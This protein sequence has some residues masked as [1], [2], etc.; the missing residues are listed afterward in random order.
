MKVAALQ[1]DV[2]SAAVEEN[3]ETVEQGLRSA[4][5]Q[6]VRLLVLPEMWASS[7]CEATPE[8]LSASAAAVDR[9]RELSRELELVVAG[10]AWGAPDAAGAPTNRLSI[11]EGGKL[12]LEYDKVHLFSPTAED[13]SFAAGGRPPAV[14][15]SGVGRLSGVLCYDLRF[16]RLFEHLA[17]QGVELLVVPAQWPGAR[18][19]HWRALIP[20]RAVELQAAVVAANRVGKAHVGRRKME[21]EFPGES[22]LVDAH[23]RLQAEAGSGPQLVVAELDPSEPG[24]LRRRVPVEKDR[25]SELYEEW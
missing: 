3:L 10:S 23:G 18:F 9:V 24:R 8:L 5:G 7:F 6:G 11:H 21:L 16:G 4:A 2:L 22:M 1:F 25:R 15:D 19:A 20:G 12:L 13:A 17:K 14:V